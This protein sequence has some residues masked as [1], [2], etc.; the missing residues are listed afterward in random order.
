MMKKTFGK[1]SLFHTRFPRAKGIHI[2]NLFKYAKEYVND[3]LK[4]NTE[5]CYCKKKIIIEERSTEILNRNQQEFCGQ[6]GLKEH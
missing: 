6:D 4:Q 1:Q 5:D 2:S 3:A